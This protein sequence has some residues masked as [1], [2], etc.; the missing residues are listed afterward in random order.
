M[1]EICWT[2]SKGWAAPQIVPTHGLKLDPLN[3]SIHYGFE[4]MGV[5]K[6]CRDPKGQLRSFRPDLFA[7]L[8]NQ[9]SEEISFPTFD[10]TEFIK[11]IDA[12]ISADASWVPQRPS[13]LHI[14]PTI[15]SLTNQLGVHAPH[16]T[17]LYVASSPVT[18]YFP[19]GDKPLRL[20]VE[21]SGAHTW[22][23]GCGE[24]GV[25]ARYGIGIKYIT[26][27][28]SKGFDNVVWVKGH[29]VVDTSPASI[30]FYWIN[31][32]NEKELVTPRLGGTLE[33]DPVRRSVLDLAQTTK[34]VVAKERDV[35]IRELVKA[36]KEKR[37]NPV[38]SPLSSC[39]RSSCAA[40]T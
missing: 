15:I 16:E 26:E 2:H 6:V 21:S 23:G 36:H 3:S 12:L 14:R 19:N 29:N 31:P 20:W 4:G 10:S 38:S 9:T 17:L 28:K 25:S 13:W 39:S 18:N 7:K 8:V 32:K 27:A 1:L 35:D 24:T 30:F 33:P 5:L 11:C 34:S 22:V 40:R 37:V